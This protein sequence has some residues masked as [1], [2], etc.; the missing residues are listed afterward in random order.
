VTDT[1]TF[2]H[3]P[4]RAVRALNL[5]LSPK[6]D[7]L[8]MEMSNLVAAG[9]RIPAAIHSLLIC[10]DQRRGRPMDT[11]DRSIGGVDYYNEVP[12]PFVGRGSLSNRK[13][14]LPSSQKHTTTTVVL[15]VRSFFPPVRRAPHAK[16]TALHLR[17]HADLILV[18]DDTK[19]R[20]L[21]SSRRR[22]RQSSS[23]PGSCV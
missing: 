5:S 9:E 17:Y 20:R 18:G 1:K 15:F 23:F 21:P 13:S 11:I 14:V 8:E 2:S 12:L 10:P 22:H 7:D 4:C 6:K 3:V 16:L 19:P